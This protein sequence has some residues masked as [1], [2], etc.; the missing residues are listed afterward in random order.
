MDRPTAL[1][2]GDTV[3]QNLNSD[4]DVINVFDPRMSVATVDRLVQRIHANPELL[5]FRRLDI[6]DAAQQVLAE[7]REVAASHAI[8]TRASPSVGSRSYVY[9]RHCDP[10]SECA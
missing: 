2:F 1:V 8:Y 7:R 10:A 6:S 5:H 4:P 3:Q 9:A